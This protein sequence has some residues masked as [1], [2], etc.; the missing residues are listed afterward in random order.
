MLLLLLP[1]VGKLTASRSGWCRGPGTPVL[2]VVL[3]GL[4]FVL[5]VEMGRTPV[6]ATPAV[7]STVDSCLLAVLALV[8]VE[9]GTSCRLASLPWKVVGWS[10]RDASIGL[11]R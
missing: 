5:L 6:P 9:A 1:N 7:C 8:V 4:L 2:S 3:V 10:R 11:L